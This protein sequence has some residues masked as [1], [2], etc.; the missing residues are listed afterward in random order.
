MTIKQSC[1]LQGCVLTGIP[2]GIFMSI[3]NWAWSMSI[4]QHTYIL[5]T[6]SNQQLSSSWIV[7]TILIYLHEFFIKYVLLIIM[8]VPACS[9]EILYVSWNHLWYVDSITLFLP[10]ISVSDLGQQR[11]GKRQEPGKVTTFFALYSHTPFTFWII[12]TTYRNCNWNYQY[13]HEQQ[14]YYMNTW[15]QHH[16]NLLGSL[17][18]GH[19]QLYPFSDYPAGVR[20]MAGQSLTPYFIR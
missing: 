7:P 13:G 1:S 6:H 14:Y 15:Y 12:P 2:M 18:S 10:G 11:R 5:L 19:I 8:S 4:L 20:V 17:Y 3:T 16:N 9:V